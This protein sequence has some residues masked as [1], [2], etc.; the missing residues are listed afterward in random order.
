[1]HQIARARLRRAGARR[2]FARGDFVMCPSPEPIAAQSRSQSQ[3]E[4]D[5]PTE[6]VTAFRRVLVPIDFSPGARLALHAAFALRRA[7][8]AEVL[9]F[10]LAEYGDGEEFLAG[11]GARWTPSELVDES[12]AQLERFV[13]HVEPGESSF[14]RVDVDL[15]VDVASAIAKAVRATS[16]TLVILAAHPKH[17]LLRSRAEKI[18]REVDCPVLL[19]RAPAEPRVELD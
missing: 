10:N 15:G 4:E 11:I 12:R 7:F 17:T 13:E 8:G 14:V 6:Q 1:M 9:L 19:L 3:M 5:E 18:T 16:A 2:T